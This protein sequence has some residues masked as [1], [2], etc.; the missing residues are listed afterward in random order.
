MDLVV[1]NVDN[2]MTVTAVVTCGIFPFYQF[3][4]DTGNNNHIQL[5]TVKC[6]LS[7]IC[8]SVFPNY[9]GTVNPHTVPR[10]THTHR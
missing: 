6:V 8:V 4:F 1:G 7:I 2:R 10:I 5:Y 9:T 3:R